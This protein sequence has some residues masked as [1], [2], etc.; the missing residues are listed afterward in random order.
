M[1][2]ARLLNCFHVN[3]LPETR[4]IFG[5]A[6]VI[7]MDGFP[8][9]DHSVWQ[10]CNRLPG[11]TASTDGCVDALHGAPIRTLPPLFPVEWHEDDEG[12]AEKEEGDDQEK[13]SQCRHMRRTD[14]AQASPDSPR[15]AGPFPKA[16]AT[17]T[18]GNSDDESSPFRTKMPSLLP[19]VVPVL[20]DW[21][22]SNVLQRMGKLEARREMLR[23]RIWEYASC[24]P[25]F[26]GGEGV[27]ISAVVER[28]DQVALCNFL[29]QCLER[30]S[31]A[32]LS[33]LQAYGLDTPTGGVE[34][35]PR[36]WN[37]MRECT[38]RVAEQELAKLRKAHS[39]YQLE[40]LP[41]QRGDLPIHA[42]G[43]RILF[44]GTEPNRGN[45]LRFRAT[46]GC[47]LGA[48]M[49][50]AYLL[51]EL[52]MNGLRETQRIF[53]RVK[54]IKL[55]GFPTQNHP[56]W[57]NWDFLACESSA[58]PPAARLAG[59]AFAVDQLHGAPVRALPRIFGGAEA[60]DTCN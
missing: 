14:F 2:L 23:K 51:D 4:H 53:G 40:D 32:P 31:V 12:Q 50:I 15:R 43:M 41:I 39:Q 24:G 25:D 45:V 29:N 42:C 18:P 8:I 47:P 26:E 38:P 27:R 48:M 55:D 33:D 17:G 36:D 10:A 1:I 11:S 7:K 5:R 19:L 58:E 37:R 13:D 21:E 9:L 49:M 6:K 35:R 34:L 60:S 28:F 57:T 52:H 20:H 22:L 59:R 46:A 54:L 44:N 16:P 56:V 30:H 3:E